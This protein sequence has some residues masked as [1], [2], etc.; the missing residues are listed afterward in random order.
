MEFQKWSQHAK[1]G[2]EEKLCQRVI[3]REPVTPEGSSTSPSIVCLQEAILSATHLHWFKLCFFNF[4]LKNPV[5]VKPSGRIF[6]KKVRLHRYYWNGLVSFQ[7]GSEELWS[8]PFSH[9]VMSGSLQPHGLQHTRP[10]C[11]SPTPTACSN[12]CPSSQWCHPAIL[13]SVVRFS[14]CLQS[15]PESGS[16]PMSQFFTSDGQSVGASA[17]VLPMNIQDWFPLGLTGLIFLSKGTLKSL[18]YHSSKASILQ[19]SAFFMV[20]LSHLYMTTGKTIALTRWIFL[21]K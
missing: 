15:F 6:L 13:S 18:Q 16:F 12:S 20:Q 5:L 3:W 19:C 4:Y 7:G 11:P 9:S 21:A 17:S 2:R 1:R 14:S 10:P 8:V